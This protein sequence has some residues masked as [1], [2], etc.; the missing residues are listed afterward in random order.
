[1]EDSPHPASSTSATYVLWQPPSRAISILLNL[2][3]V[4]RLRDAT[5]AAAGE[6]AGGVLFGS[7]DAARQVPLVRID[8][9]E[10]VAS[11]HIRG[12]AYILSQQD[13]RVLSKVLTRGADRKGMAPVGFFRTHLRKGLYLD[14]ADF[15]LFHDHFSGVC[16]VFLVA[17]R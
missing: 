16:N 14:E 6:E 11:E 1:M 5:R 7:C 13:T 8:A 10:L 15:S 3:L 9:F 17:R 2:D 12:P 4:D